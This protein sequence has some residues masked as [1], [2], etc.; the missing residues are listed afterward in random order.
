[1][2][3]TLLVMF[4]FLSLTVMGGNLIVQTNAP[5]SDTTTSQVM[6]PGG[7]TNASTTVINEKE[8]LRE[9]QKMEVKE[10]EYKRE[11]KEWKKRNQK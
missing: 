4:C 7:A 1:M 9:K 2:K 6:G 5:T 10:K 11:K 3:Q 8:Q